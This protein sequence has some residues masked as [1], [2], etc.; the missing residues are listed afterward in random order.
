MIFFGKSGKI[1]LFH[2]M[3]LSAHRSQAKVCSKLCDTDVHLHSEA[4]IFVQ[5]STMLNEVS[6]FL[7]LALFRFHIRVVVH[8]GVT[9]IVR[10]QCAIVKS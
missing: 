7:Q 1:S 4:F 2:E 9:L 3:F 8:L 6:I 5:M 10:E